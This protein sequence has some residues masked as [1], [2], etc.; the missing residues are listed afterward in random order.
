MIRFLILALLVGCTMPS[1]DASPTKVEDDIVY[2][3]GIVSENP[4]QILDTADDDDSATQDTEDVVEEEEET[5]I[6]YEDCSG[7]VGDHPCNLEFLDQNGDTWNLWEHT[8]TV[9]VVDFSTIWCGVCKSIAGDAQAFQDAYTDLGHDV[10]WVSVL[11]D[12]PNWGVPPVE[13]EIQTWVSSYGMTTSPVLLGDRTVID[14][15]AESGIPIVSWPTLIIVDQNM[16]IAFGIG[17]WSESM[18]TSELENV[19]GI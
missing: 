5:P 15:T 9:M 8:G 16:R 1:E 13:S 11:V 10:L 2:D 7:R 6:T 14:T 18:I 3:E 19:L 4:P 12:G 17:G